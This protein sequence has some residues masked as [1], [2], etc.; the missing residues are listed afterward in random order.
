MKSPAEVPGIFGQRTC[1]DG[2]Y[3]IGEQYH[4]ATLEPVNEFL[5]NKFS[6]GKIEEIGSGRSARDT[7]P[8]IRD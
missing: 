5:E 6:I 7:H 1:R 8:P 4:V 2:D 3:F